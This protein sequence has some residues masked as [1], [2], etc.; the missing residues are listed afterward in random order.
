MKDSQK[1]FVAPLLI[2]IIAV[3]AIG[4]GVY[5]YSSKNGPSNTNES[6][7]SNQTPPLATDNSIN[8]NV[9]TQNSSGTLSASPVTTT[10]AGG[11]CSTTL[12]WKA[13]PNGYVMY[14]GV[15]LSSGA[16]G[17]QPFSRVNTTGIMF[18]L[19][20]DQSM[21]PATKLASV[22]VKCVTAKT[23]PVQSVQWPFFFSIS[24]SSLVQN[25]SYKLTGSIS[26]AASSSP[27]Y[28]S[29]Q[30]SDGSLYYDAFLSSPAPMTDKNGNATI[31]QTVSI[32]SSGQDGQWIAWVTIGG[33]MSQKTTIAVST[34]STQK[35]SI[36]SISPTT[37]TPGGTVFIYGSN[38][39]GGF[40][41]NLVI[42]NK[43]GGSMRA[44]PTTSGGISGFYFVVPANILPGTYSILVEDMNSKLDSNPVTLIIATTSNS[45]VCGAVG[46]VNLDGKISQADTD[47]IYSYLAGNTTL[48]S[49]Q[50]QN[51]DVDGNKTIDGLVDIPYITRYLNGQA[52]T[53]SACSQ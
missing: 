43:G 21:S 44:T 26:S 16:G 30:R 28:F 17:L 14:N 52:T 42:F 4:A 32:S 15:L 39:S 37:V 20:S 31:T 1:G 46:D 38:F 27:I 22:F 19:H 33:K 10:T 5:Y 23:I 53:F 40:Y 35:P 25:Q 2:I 24:P 47:L 48:T 36:T 18:E 41:D 9:S 6:L 7:N 11:N 51:A 49:A 50:K 13:T 45:L 12:S 34:A 3:L 8:N 29:L